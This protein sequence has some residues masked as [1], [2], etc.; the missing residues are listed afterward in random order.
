MGVILFLSVS[1]FFPSSAFLG[2][3][4]NLETL[5]KTNLPRALANPII[6]SAKAAIIGTGMFFKF[7]FFPMVWGEILTICVAHAYILS[8][9]IRMN[10]GHKV[11]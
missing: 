1:S 2:T 6:P 5:T 9:G 10:E 4:P 7:F 3:H 11:S 8:E